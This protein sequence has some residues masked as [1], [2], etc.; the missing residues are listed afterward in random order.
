MTA[1]SNKCIN[2]TCL[3]LSL[4]VLVTAIIF[5]SLFLSYLHFELHLLDNNHLLVGSATALLSA[6][7]VVTLFLRTRFLSSQVEHKEFE[8]SHLYE[9]NIFF[10]LLANKSVDMVHIN[11]AS[12]KILYV[13]PATYDLLGYQKNEI[14]SQTADNFIHPEDRATIHEDMRQVAQG[15]DVPPREIRLLKKSGNIL[16]VEVKGFSLNTGENE[17]YIGA[18]L[19]DISQIKQNAALLKTSDEWET[20]FNSIQDFVSVHDQDFRIVRANSALC[21]LLGKSREEIV[22]KHCYQL[23][24]GLDAPIENCLQ[25][26][27]ADTGHAITEIISDPHIGVPLEITC[28]PLFNDEGTFKGSVHIARI[29]EDK[30]KDITQKYIPICSACK[31]I[32]D[33]KSDWISTEE[34]FRTK[35]KCE[36]THTVCNDCAQVLYPEYLRKG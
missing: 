22:G 5:E 32:R 30:K 14:I 36:F 31:K 25:R 27:T 35:Y 2:I 6:I 8:L 33:S 15:H 20:T 28:S 11:D 16:D 18:I 26:K 17:R 24:H 12:G 29:S 19:R 13:N 1:P 23:F 10:K 4:L 9:E 7:L 21:E 34:Y 3:I